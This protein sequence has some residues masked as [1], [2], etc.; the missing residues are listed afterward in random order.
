M[1]HRIAPQPALP[2]F[3]VEVGYLNDLSTRWKL[4]YVPRKEGL[5][6]MSA[7][8]LAMWRD[9]RPALANYRHVSL[10]HPYSVI[11]RDCLVFVDNAISDWQSLLTGNMPYMPLDNNRLETLNQYTRKL[12][13][14]PGDRLEIKY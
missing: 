1:T 2:E 4:Y 14:I 10:L 6:Q 13:S 11:V 7:A 12:E 3:Y 9:H 5:P 8:F